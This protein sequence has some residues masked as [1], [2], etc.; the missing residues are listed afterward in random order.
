[1]QTEVNIS[2][3]TQQFT[4]APSITGNASYA[5]LS[6]KADGLPDM[7]LNLVKIYFTKQ[8]LKGEGHNHTQRMW[9]PVF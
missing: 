9:L 4:C 5:L 1:M 2:D 3:F 7:N 8:N 6:R